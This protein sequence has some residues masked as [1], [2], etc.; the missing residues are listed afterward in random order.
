[1]NVVYALL[2]ILCRA[3]RF[4]PLAS[5]SSAAAAARMAIRF[6]CVLMVMTNLGAADRIL[7]HGHRGARAVRP[8]NTLPAFE[9]AIAA[10]VDVLELDLAV[11]RDNVLVVSHDPVMNLT[12][13]SGPE[14]AKRTIR[15]MTFA[16]LQQWD[17]GSKVNPEFPNQQPAPGARVPSLEQVLK[18]AARGRFDFNIET[19]IFKDR[20][21]LTPSPEE[22][23]RLLAE[24]LRKHSVVSRTIVQSFDYRTLHAMKKILPEVRLAALYAGPPKSFVA[25]AREAGAGIV[26]PHHLLVT[27]EQVEEAHAAGLQVVPWT[28]NTERDWERLI[29]AKVDA[30]ITDDPARLLAFLK[31]R[32]AASKPPAP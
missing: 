22:F 3:A 28:A 11:T 18:L 32:V 20:P 2:M 31:Q 15:E 4:A 12:Y 27:A 10:G 8:E 26:S 14:G 16:E 23:A 30:I 29:R 21:Q 5:A 6:L 13:C 19:K 1:M 9:Y 25:I 7:V 17:C 24:A